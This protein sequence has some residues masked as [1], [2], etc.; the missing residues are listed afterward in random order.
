MIRP[1]YRREN[2]QVTAVIELPQ[3]E[4]GSLHWQGSRILLHNGQQALHLPG[5]F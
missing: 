4:D 5:A 1:S 2:G 3:G